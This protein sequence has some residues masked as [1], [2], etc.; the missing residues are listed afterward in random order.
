MALLQVKFTTSGT[1]YAMCHLYTHSF[2]FVRYHNDRM[3]N[4]DTAR[5]VRVKNDP[6]GSTLVLSGALSPAD[7]GNY[8]C[9][10]YNVRPS[11][12]MVHVL[13]EGNSAE[14]VQNSGDG[15]S[16]STGGKDGRGENPPP[17]AAVQSNDGGA[18]AACAATNFIVLM[19]SVLAML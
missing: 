18:P 4:Y 8:T 6:T 13:S 16:V 3:I 14:A 10:P 2:P 9:L 11:S 19:A 15:G 1:L 7:S 12:V 5:G 17:S